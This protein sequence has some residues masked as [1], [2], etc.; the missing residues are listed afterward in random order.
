MTQVLHSKLSYH[1][2][3]D[4]L[5]AFA[6]LSVVVF[7]VF[8]NWLKG[9]FVGVD[10]F[11]VIS[12]FLITSHIFE[13]LEKETFSFTDFFSRRIRRIFPALVLI[14]AASL[15]FGWLVLLKDEYAQLAKHVASGTLFIVNFIL[16]DESGY[17]DNAGETKP[18]LHLWSLAV[19]EQFYIVWP[20]VLWL[21]WKIKFNLLA[22][23]VLVAVI[24]FAFNLKFVEAKPIEIF[25][26]PIGRFWELLSGSILAWLMLY[27]Q[28]MLTRS[29]LNVDRYLVRAMYWRKV[30]SDGKAASNFFSFLGLLILFYSILQ[31]NESLNFPGLWTLLPILG[32]LCVIWSGSNA[33]CNHIFLMN[34][35]AIWFGL[36]SY[37]L[38][39]W[40]WPILAFLQIIEGEMP[41]R[42]VRII[43]V[44][45]SILLAWLTYKLIEKPI[46]FGQRKTLKTIFLLLLMIIVGAV[47]Y[48]AH[49][50]GGLTKWN[51]AVE[52]I[53]N[54][55][56]DWSYPKGLEK[57][58]EGENTYYSTSKKQ[59]SVVLFGDSHIEQ[60][61]PR[62]VDLYLKGNA[63]ETAFITGGGCPPIPNVYSDG[64][65]HE[66]CFKL[67]ERFHNLL[68]NNP[69]E[70]IIV[71]A[72]F[73][74]YLAQSH[75]KGAKYTY[76]FN[77]DKQTVPLTSLD[78]IAR[79]RQSFYDFANKLSEKY[80]LIVLLDLPAGEKFS[81][82]YLVN[83]SNEKRPIPISGKILA[84]PF[85]QDHLQVAL[86]KEM[87]EIFST[88]KVE[89]VS[90][91]D[92]I[93]PDGICMA[94]SSDGKP[95]YKDSS[96]M[97]PWFVIE[98]MDV[99]DFYILT[100]QEK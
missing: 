23:T 36:I 99:L 61:G 14:M 7:H 46:R 74:G 57:I 25:F 33:W 50:K 64:D 93:C 21:A 87:V 95:I 19:E 22:L 91:S 98:K 62:V 68:K 77:D 84:N 11:F 54:A 32:A 90:Q 45:L 69:I 97:R 53:S 76:Y 92:H 26:W 65:V 85:D 3:I 29:R 78:G 80:R 52:Y 71:G 35:I 5:R 67:F 1:A 81:P 88:S 27:K 18:M 86:E 55:K 39:L 40:H 10:I 82:N 96:H 20:L 70:T 43:A 17:F 49:F 59:P 31:I 15:F 58:V 41:H 24:S 30:T 89:T 2:E 72:S 37:P 12:G 6:V 73:N 60:Y 56:G 38:Y 16:V 8:P 13:K 28:E 79:A 75:S 42:Y 9:G 4:G 51:T 100:K 83:D 94:L 47:G 66:H 44:L 48:N 63:R 34:P